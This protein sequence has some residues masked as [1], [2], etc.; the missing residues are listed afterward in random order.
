M[1][2]KITDI[3][4]SARVSIALRLLAVLFA[5][6]V[7]ATACSSDGSGQEISSDTLGTEIDF[8]YAGFDGEKLTFSD[9]SDGPVVLNFFASWCPTCISEM[10]DFESVHQAFG[11]DV[12]FLGLSVQ[13]RVTDA[14]Q[15]VADTGIS[16]AVGNDQNG[17]VFSLFNGLGM[18]TTVFIDADGTVARVHTGVYDAESLTEAI[19][20]HL[21]S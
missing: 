12:T 13:D 11:S 20:D 21:L 2:R 4:H 7:V 18:P 5:F 10:P 6:G 8:T 19:N 15:L 9:L 14:K 1:T 3:P 17:D 16:Y